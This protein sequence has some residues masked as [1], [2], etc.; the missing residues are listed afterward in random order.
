MQFSLAPIVNANWAFG[1]ARWALSMSASG[2]SPRPRARADSA[3]TVVAVTASIPH[4]I[5]PSDNATIDIA[6]GK[7]MASS[8]V[9]APRSLR[10]NGQCAAKE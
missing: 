1:I 8:T 9:T 10:D 6:T 4:W 2:C 5:A 7:P 3:A